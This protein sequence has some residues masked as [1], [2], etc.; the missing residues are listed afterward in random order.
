VEA[1]TKALLTDG[2]F[3]HPSARYFMEFSE[4]SLPARKTFRN[5]VAY[6]LGFIGSLSTSESVL[7]EVVRKAR[8]EEHSKLVAGKGQ[9]ESSVER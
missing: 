9:R 4:S 5:K 1:S 8:R 3:I 7:A 6:A 2:T